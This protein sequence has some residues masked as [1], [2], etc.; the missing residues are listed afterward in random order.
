MKS[1]WM[2]ILNY[3]V[4]SICLMLFYTLWTD[5]IKGLIIGLILFFLILNTHQLNYFKSLS[6]FRPRYLWYLL[7]VLLEW[8]VAL[9]IQFNVWG[10]AY[11]DAIANASSKTL[12]RAF[13]IQLLLIIREEVATSFC[14]LMLA[15]LVMRLLKVEALNKPNLQLALLVM[16]IFFAIGH[17]PN[18][19]YLTKQPALNKTVS[20]LGA[21]FVFVNAFILG[22][23]LKTIYIRTRSIQTCVAVHFLCNLR[24]AFFPI[25]AGRQGDL[26][27]IE[28]IG[29]EALILVIYIVAIIVLWRKQ[30]H[31]E[32][33][34]EVYT[35]LDAEPFELYA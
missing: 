10:S 11:W 4:L 22:M 15:F 14:W 12:L 16:A 3:A 23:F 21:I 2:K 20:I 1:Y 25:I 8:L 32:R 24:R 33:L 29:Y 35:A 9:P 5:P 26:L 18:A 19:V 6:Q 31:L 30:W 17:F 13:S 27:T 7:P 28:L 34:D